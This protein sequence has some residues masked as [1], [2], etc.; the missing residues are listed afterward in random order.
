MPGAVAVSLLVGLATARAVRGGRLVRPQV[1][2]E[3]LPKLSVVEQVLGSGRLSGWVMAKVGGH[4]PGRG[5]SAD[6]GAGLGRGLAA[7]VRLCSLCG[8]AAEL[9]FVLRGFDQGFGG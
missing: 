8:A 7:G 6:A 2:T 1:P 4:G 5:G 9:D 3:Y